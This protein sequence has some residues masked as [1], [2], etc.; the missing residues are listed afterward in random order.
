MRGSKFVKAVNF[1]AARFVRDDDLDYKPA[2]LLIDFC[3]LGSYS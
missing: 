3:T 2:A 1:R